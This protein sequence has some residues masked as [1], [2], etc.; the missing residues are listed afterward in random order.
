MQAIDAACQRLIA[1]ETSIGRIDKVRLTPVVHNLLCGPTLLLNADACYRTQLLHELP[2]L[3]SDL[4][5]S[6]ASILQIAHAAQVTQRS[7]P[8]PPAA[9]EAA[10]TGTETKPPH[11]AVSV[12]S[13]VDGLV[14]REPD[15]AQDSTK[16]VGSLSAR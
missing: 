1:S 13:A 16:G 7:A 9:A 12:D 4:D 10:Y 15:R 2:A 5:A 6:A 8:E 3:L 14:G 11:S